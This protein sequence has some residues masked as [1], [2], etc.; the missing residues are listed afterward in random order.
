MLGAV[1]A[2]ATVWGDAGRGADDRRTRRAASPN[3][4][5]A[6]TS[7]LVVDGA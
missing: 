4:V 6:P 1:A 3:C 5:T 2:M 7:S